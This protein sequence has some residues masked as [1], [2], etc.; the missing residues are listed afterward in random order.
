MTTLEQKAKCFFGVSSFSSL[1]LLC[2]FFAFLHGLRGKKW[3]I[4]VLIPR[5]YKIKLDIYTA[6]DKR[7]PLHV[8]KIRERK[9]LHNKKKNSSKFIISTL[10]VYDSFFPWASCCCFFNSHFRITLLV[11]KNRPQSSV[12][13]IWQNIKPAGR[14]A[15]RRK[16][17]N[18]FRFLNHQ[19][20]LPF[21]NG[22]Q[23][24]NNVR[25]FL[26]SYSYVVTRS[27]SWIAIEEL[28]ERRMNVL[29][30]LSISP[31]SLSFRVAKRAH[32]H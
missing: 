26:W 11:V 21:K 1:L 13:E 5:K 20:L 12:S 16:T 4:Y 18:N 9:M 29:L 24:Q 28:R 19:A 14:K 32:L 23:C 2:N 10:T 15:G 27:S 22:Q 7:E 30:H 3:S 8:H 25:I 17:S 6:E 31:T